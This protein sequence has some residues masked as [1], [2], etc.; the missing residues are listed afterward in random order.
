MGHRGSY[1]DLYHSVLFSSKSFTVSGLTFRSLISFEFI[2]VY[3]VRKFSNFILLHIA[4]QFS[5]HHLLKRQSLPHCNI[6]ASFCLISLTPCLQKYGICRHVGLSLG[7]LVPLV[8]ISIFVPVP[9]CLD[10]C[11]FVVQSEV[12]KVDFSSSILLSQDCF[13]YLGSSVFHYEL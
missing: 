5:Q 3:G 10:D 8:C 13:G 4:V 6:F 9:Y 2:F 1:C 7:Y 11:S 12:R